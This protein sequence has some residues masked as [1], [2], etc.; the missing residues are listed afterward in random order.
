MMK[1]AFFLIVIIVF[2]FSSL[3]FAAGASENDSNEALAESLRVR[4]LLGLNADK[5]YVR[6]INS[7]PELQSTADKIGIVLTDDELKELIVRDTLIKEAALLKES[8]YP[9]LKEKQDNIATNNHWRP[10]FA[11][12]YLDHHENGAIKIGVVNLE[13]NRNVAEKLKESFSYPSRVLFYD[14][15]IS[16]TDLLSLQSKVN[17]LK[18]IYPIKYTDGSIQENKVIVG[19]P[20]EYKEI[21]DSELITRLDPQN[22]EIR[23]DS[24]KTQSLSKTAYTRPLKG[25]LAITVG[26]SGCTGAFS[27]RRLLP[28]NTYKYYYITA[29]HCGT[30]DDNASQGGSSI[31]TVFVK[32][33]SGSV[34]MLAIETARA[35]VGHQIYNSNTAPL[36]TVNITAI[37]STDI[38]GTYVCQSGKN[39][40]SSTCGTLDSLTY[41][42]GSLF[43]M[44]KT[45]HSQAKLGDSGATVFERRASDPPEKRM[46]HGVLS[47]IL[48]TG[49]INANYTTVG[50]YYSHVKGVFSILGP[51]GQVL[52]EH[53][54]Y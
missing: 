12:V 52:T 1:K 41:A 36:A 23:F 46:V 47:G 37:N 18:T 20:E 5:D 25:G 10:I 31:G 33:N 54:S 24:I 42:P 44:R 27:A 22:I 19:L 32:Q 43:N 49:D 14:T 3:P 28:D 4:A 13:K 38:I 53:V 29:G 26:T 9:E 6:K 15:D 16:E 30:W 48:Y 35:N 7:S 34:D 51:E 45:N 40:T 21:F 17:E 39:S 11:G 50:M 2:M 8:I